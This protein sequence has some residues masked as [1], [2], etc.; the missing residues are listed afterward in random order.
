MYDIREN[1]HQELFYL[2][3]QALAPIDIHIPSPLGT[4]PNYVYVRV[5]AGTDLRAVAVRMDVGGLRT[6][7]V[8]LAPGEGA[9]TPA[10]T[11]SK[12]DGLEWT[13]VGCG[14]VSRGNGT[15]TLEGWPAALPQ[16][17]L[18]ITTWLRFVTSGLAD[19][20]IAAQADPLWAPTGVPLGGIGGGRVDICRD[21]RFRNF[22]MNNNQD[23]PVEDPDGLPGAFL[24]V[25]EGTTVR[26]LASRLVLPG[27]EVA[28]SLTFDARFPQAT[29]GAPA[30]FPGLDVSVTLSGT[31]CP[32]DLRRATLPGFLVRWAVTN[33]GAE[34]RTVDVTLGWPN[35]IGQGGG[36]GRGETSIGY[37]DG[38]YHHWDDPTGRSEAMAAT[39]AMT[40]V[41]FT[42]TPSHVHRA[43]AG[44]HLLAVAGAGTASWGD[45]RGAVTTTL[46]IPAG[47][48]ATATMAVAVA[49]PHWID[50]GDV[51]RGVYWQNTCATV[52]EIAGIL[53]GEA[54]DILREAGALAALLADSTLPAWLQ[55]RLSNCTYPL[56]TNSVCYADGRFSINEGPTEMSGCY[57]TIDQRLAAHPATQLLFPML[58]ATELGL[59]ARIQGPDGSI[60][61]DLGCAN[62]ERD[63]QVQKWPDIP[64]SFVIQTAR[65]AWS[66]GDADF[67]R[68]MFPHAKM[69][70]LQHAE[71]ADAGGGVPQLGHGLGTSYDSYHYYGTTAYMGTLW[72]AALAIY[73]KWA[74]RLG[75]SDLLDRVPGWR[76]AAIARME[77]DLWNGRYYDAYGSVSGPHRDTCHGG[78]LAGEVYARLL[79]GAD[80]LSDERMRSVLD[81]LAS[82]N[83]STKFAIPPDEASPDGSVG[84]D[85]GW[86]PYIEGFMLTAF[87]ILDDARLWPIWERMAL[88]M[89]NNGRRPCDTRLMY[90]P[91]T[92]EPSWGSYYMTAPASWL[93]YDAARDFF[94]TP[95]TGT[96]RLRTTADGRF[97]L[98]HPCFWAVADIQDG[99]VTLTITR[100]FTDGLTLRALELPAGAT[101][102]VDGT[103][104]PASG[105]GV[106]GTATLPAP[107]ALTPG[108]TVTWS[109]KQKVTA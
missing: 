25:G 66:T 89:D 6:E 17:D 32:H 79:A 109:V 91:D 36:I 104:L 62:L 23:A 26:E 73:E 96:L 101:A 77:A 76:A 103:A 14:H 42:G 49:M 50:N 2:G 58:N 40:G 88:A 34:T 100:V 69:A 61:H 20:Q 9:P 15:L 54:D 47:A 27:H 70:M 85:F 48:T 59:F 53:L 107:A 37:G 56:V 43:S 108:A 95:E 86:L 80:V 24:A 38:Y 98:V 8:A 10:T 72:L 33:T 1:E 93:V 12:V 105:E 63:G 87:A 65:H 46:T 55:Q 92:G 4:L 84:A 106:Y 35:L 102:V 30:I 21:G 81:S 74:A 18:L 31:L 83:G 22:S 78:Q 41:R 19:D 99:T 71:H 39:P 28:P 29:L 16:V 44:E 52:D 11:P 13:C 82:L 68:A 57:G 45:G 75:K 7:H 51:D 90:R 67:E 94:Y 97:P 64:C 5:P 60:P 3:A